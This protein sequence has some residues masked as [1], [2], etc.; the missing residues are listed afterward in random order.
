MIT[1]LIIDWPLLLIMWGQ[2]TCCGASTQFLGW[3]DW[4]ILLL[5]LHDCLINYT[6]DCN[7]SVYVL[8]WDSLIYFRRNIWQLGFIKHEI[9]KWNNNCLQFFHHHPCDV[10]FHSVVIV[11]MWIHQITVHATISECFSVALVRAWWSRVGGDHTP[12][13]Y[14]GRRCTARSAYARSFRY[15][16]VA[17]SRSDWRHKLCR[18]FVVGLFR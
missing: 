14:R 2:I 8:K 17:F 1:W 13:Y 15:R 11:K 7:V 18:D 16:I 12:T 5:L 6:S 9:M 4:M 3:M 10:Q